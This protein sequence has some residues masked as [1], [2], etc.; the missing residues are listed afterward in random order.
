MR[1]LRNRALI[2]CCFD[3]V[4]GDHAEDAG[5]Q[6]AGALV[7]NQ[8]V[9]VAAVREDLRPLLGV[10]LVRDLK[11]DLSARIG[12]DVPGVRFDRRYV[13]ALRDFADAILDVSPSLSKFQCYSS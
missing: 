6:A 1:L 12:L 13:L 5:A 9:D 2:K 3:D 8:L 10:A 4:A 7:G 11:D